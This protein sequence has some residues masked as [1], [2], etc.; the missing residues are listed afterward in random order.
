VN[1]TINTASDNDEIKNSE[2]CVRRHKGDKDEIY[3]KRYRKT[4][5]QHH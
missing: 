1:H 5:E 2:N 4:M 3:K